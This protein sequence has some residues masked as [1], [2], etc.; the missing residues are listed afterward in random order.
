MP[1]VSH[2]GVIRDNNEDLFENLF[3]LPNDV[4]TC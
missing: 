3:A 2:F 4:R 1:L